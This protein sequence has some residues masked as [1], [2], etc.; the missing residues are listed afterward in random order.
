LNGHKLVYSPDGI[1]I[2]PGNL[3]P[4]TVLTKVNLSAPMVRCKIN[5]N[6]P[7]S[8]SRHQL[9]VEG[10]LVQYIP[11]HLLQ[12]WVVRAFPLLSPGRVLVPEHSNCTQCLSQGGVNAQITA[13]SFCSIE[14]YEMV[15][16]IKAD[17]V[18]AGIRFLK[19]YGR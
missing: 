2:I 18:T 4:L 7:F 12:Q 3:N 16:G 17:L 14:W 1:V 8:S 5:M 19:R 15:R 11:D 6:F 13:F 10:Q 9:T